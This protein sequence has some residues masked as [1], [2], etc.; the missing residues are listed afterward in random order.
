M[1][2]RRPW[3]IS[4]LAAV[5]LAGGCVAKTAIPWADDDDDDTSGD[6]DTT[7]GDDDVSD[8]DTTEND[9]GFGEIVAD[10]DGELMGVVSLSADLQPMLDAGCDC[11]QQGN[12]SIHDLS[13]GK[14][15]AAWID[16]PSQFDPGEVLVVPGDPESSVVFWKLLGCYPIFPYAG[17][18]MP[19]NAASPSLEELTLYYNWMLQ[20]GADN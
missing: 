3:S 17:V 14:V 12:P 20:G 16:Q 13:P 11:H 4:L 15:W 10:P 18:A 5:L 19:P 6:D 1:P 8:D 7:G 9:C 2:A